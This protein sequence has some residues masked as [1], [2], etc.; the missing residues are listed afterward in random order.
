MNCC[1]TAMSPY[2]HKIDVFN[3]SD[4]FSTCVDITK[5]NTTYS[6]HYSISCVVNTLRKNP[7]GIT[8]S[9]VTQKQILFV[10][11]FVEKNQPGI[12]NPG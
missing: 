5:C 10:I 6:L 11:I 9:R 1:I 4:K 12:K 8:T 2:R 3:N 7:L